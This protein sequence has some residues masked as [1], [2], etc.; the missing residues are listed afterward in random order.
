M[1]PEPLVKEL[2]FDATR[3][4]RIRVP[5]FRLEKAGIVELGLPEGWGPAEDRGLEA[6]I[7]GEATVRRISIHFADVFV[8]RREEWLRRLL[9]GRTV[10]G[11]LARTAGVR[12]E[13]ANEM[14]DRCG[15]DARMSIDEVAW[16]DRKLIGFEMAALRA[17]VVVVDDLGFDPTGETRFVRH[18]LQEAASRGTSLLALRYPASFE[19]N[20][21]SAHRVSL[22]LDGSE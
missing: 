12:R 2:A 10:G 3:V 6:F 1:R 4:G 7:Q 11:Q 17:D 20:P 9:G 16:T 21:W 8:V 19:T 15:V 14:C 5:D 22:T 13:V 18:I